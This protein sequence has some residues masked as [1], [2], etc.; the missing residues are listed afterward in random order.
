MIT[1]LV[2]GQ[3][4][5]TVTVEIS[6]VKS[7]RINPVLLRDQVPGHSAGV[8]FEVVAEGPVT[9]H[10]EEC[11]MVSIRA[12]DLQVVVFAPYPDT[13]LGVHNSANTR[14]SLAQEYALELENYEGLAGE[15][16]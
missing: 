16:K 9:Q 5:A 3:V 6:H 8:S 1:L 4:Q 7:F 11:V 14:R 10:L 12:H 13:F 15:S 2:D